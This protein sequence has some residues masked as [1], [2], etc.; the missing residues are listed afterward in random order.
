M[1][2][3]FYKGSVFPVSAPLIHQA[4]CP[5]VYGDNGSDRVDLLH[6]SIQ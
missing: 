1:R 4:N 5:D 6:G 3:R 2:I